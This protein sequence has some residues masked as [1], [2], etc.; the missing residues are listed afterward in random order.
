MKAK[1]E[2]RVED[3][4][5]IEGWGISDRLKTQLKKIEPV[6]QDFGTERHWKPHVLLSSMLRKICESQIDREYVELVLKVYW[7][8]RNNRNPHTILQEIAQSEFNLQPATL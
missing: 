6:Y 4:V 7:M 2:L 1:K 5:A 3:I 8:L